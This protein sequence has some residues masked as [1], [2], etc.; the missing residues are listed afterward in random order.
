MDRRIVGKRKRRGIVCLAF[1]ATTLPVAGCALS[2]AP[3]NKV[4]AQTR[5][6]H[7]ERPP[8]E[9]LDSAPRSFGV[10]VTAAG[11]AGAELALGSLGDPFL[12]RAT[13]PA[14]GAAREAEPPHVQIPSSGPA[15]PAVRLARVEPKYAKALSKPS[16]LHASAESFEQQVLRSDVP[17]LV[18]FYASWCGPCKALAPTL[19]ELAGE[20]PD[21]RIVKVDIDAA[22]DLAARYGV[23]SVPS[24]LV[25]KDGQITAKQ[26]G[27]TSKARLQAMLQM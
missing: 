24:L 26:T 3:Q 15:A 23:R 7:A 10:P 2:R 25:F 4:A 18:D 20:N 8:A 12:E 13:G 16:V 5:P 19:E 1:V 6:A 17:V 27:A 9:V 14:P 21:A 22:P 11:L